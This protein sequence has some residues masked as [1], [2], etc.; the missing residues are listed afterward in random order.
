MDSIVQIGN[1]SLL[2]TAESRWKQDNRYI[3]NICGYTARH[4]Y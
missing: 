3:G 1:S 2:S 4:F